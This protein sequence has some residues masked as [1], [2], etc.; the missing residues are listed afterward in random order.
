VPHVRDVR[1]PVITLEGKVHDQR[2]RLA[3]IETLLLSSP[4]QLTTPPASTGASCEPWPAL[5]LGLVTAQIWT[6][7][8]V[9][10]AGQFT[11]AS[12]MIN[13]HGK[14]DAKIDSKIG[15]LDSKIDTLELKLT[16]R[17][18][19]VETKI[20]KLDVKVSDHGQRLAHIEGILLPRP[21]P[22]RTG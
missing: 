6:L 11:L 2:G 19:R 13:Q 10:I 1:A 8:G 14:L 17:I 7:I 15:G 12:L 22:R 4:R 18:D 9:V 20:D 3:H 21:R 16:A 5:I